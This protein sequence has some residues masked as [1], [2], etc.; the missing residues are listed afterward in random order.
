MSDL[1]SASFQTKIRFKELGGG[2]V[3]IVASNVSY[4][5]TCALPETYS[6]PATV[7]LHVYIS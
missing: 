2:Q 7:H 4:E 5:L 1:T 3:V 6:P